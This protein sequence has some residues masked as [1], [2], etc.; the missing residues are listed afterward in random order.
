MRRQ[1]VDVLTLKK[2]RTLEEAEAYFQKAI[3]VIARHGLKRLEVIAVTTK[4]RGH[5][6]VNPDIVQIWE[7]E[8]ENPFAPL[9]QDPD[10]HALIPTRDALFDMPKL[11][12][13]LGT[14]R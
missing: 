1:F 11:Q 10:Y 8:A 9:G 2:G 4:M 3:P 13:W 5:D 6:E 12:G 14:I 7:V